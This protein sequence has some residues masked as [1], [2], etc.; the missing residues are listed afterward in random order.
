MIARDDL[1]PAWSALQDLRDD[2]SRV[3]LVSEL[4]TVAA[5]EHW[6]SPSYRRDSAALH[7]TWILDEAAIAPVIAAVRSARAPVRRRGSRRVCPE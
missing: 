3:L 7:F 2:F 6:L 1:V 5:D 4:R